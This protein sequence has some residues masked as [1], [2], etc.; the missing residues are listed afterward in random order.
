MN[1]DLI[2]DIE[3]DSSNRLDINYEVNENVDN[4]TDDTTNHLNDKYQECNAIMVK[5]NILFIAVKV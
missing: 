2:V 5:F 4:K 1:S 3:Y